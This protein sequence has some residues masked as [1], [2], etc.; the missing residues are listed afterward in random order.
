M[1]FNICMLTVLFDCTFIEGAVIN[2]PIKIYIT[3]KN[4]CIYIFVA[5]EFIMIYLYICIKNIC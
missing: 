2:L 3:K 5:S 4:T 1:F